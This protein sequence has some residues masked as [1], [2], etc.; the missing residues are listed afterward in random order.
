MKW[1]ALQH[2]GIRFPPAYESRQIKIRIRGEEVD[3]N[4]EQEEMVYQ[5]A[6]KKD[7][8]Y[9]QD[10]VFQ[11]NFTVDFAKT[12][13]REFRKISYKDIDFSDAYRIVDEEKAER[14]KRKEEEKEAR[15]KK[16]KE[17]KEA[18]IKKRKE[19]KEAMA[20]MT[21]EEREEFAKKIKEEREARAK[22]KKEEREAR[23][24][25]K[26]AERDKLKRKYGTAIM[27]GKKV[28]IANYMAEPPG[29]FIGRG[30]HPLRGRWKPR[31]DFKDVTLNLGKQAKVPKGD[32]GK[33]VSQSDATWLAKWTDHL[34]GNT[35]YVWL[36]D[37][38]GVKQDK[39]KE[40]YDKVAT[41]GK[42]I[43][44]I[45]KEM[46]RD[47]KSKDEKTRTI[48]TV[49]YLIYSTAMR[50]GDEKDSDEADTVGA[51]TLRK[52]H[53]TIT[54]NAVKFDFLGK[55][56]VE[57]QK[58]VK[59]EGDD[60]QFQENLKRIIGK[61]KPKDEIFDKIT[62]RRVNAYYSKI[63]PGMTAKV[64]RTYLA[65]KAVKDYLAKHDTIK[66]KSVDAKIH[67]AKLANLEAAKKCNHKR[68]I[69]KTFEKG[70]Q[71]RRDN[72]KIRM[73]KKPWEKT[74]KRR[75]Q[76]KDSE[77]KTDIQRKNKNKRIRRL[78]KQ[79]R[80]Q[81]ERHGMQIEKMKLQI[82]LTGKTK[83]YNL[84]T[85]LRNYID[86]RMFK[87]WADHVGVEWEKMYTSALQKKFLWVQNEK[88][89]WSEM[90]R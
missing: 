26:N 79:I 67:H 32:W 57:W 61:K 27:N 42:E 4:I 71:K 85:S 18:R 59:A 41:L 6:K 46:V 60:K 55:D 66:E 70:L 21:K 83:D 10:S 38:A 40:K 69:P 33:I 8:P 54:E 86:P 29:I 1:K 72:L 51:T 11:K 2:N 90:S 30:D 5:W 19:E 7:T 50:V 87:A 16:R 74:E 81:K 17:E 22:K 84:G 3:L 34:T 36:A 77:P 53:I 68:T 9:V 39:D 75:T 49:C 44:E 80:G 24:K 78:N 43:G 25:E 48:A 20:K 88:P 31:V 58:T 13:N 47:M 62:S 15:I 52:E 65:T 73:E 45:L 82:T 37:T 23:A 89:K 12:L 14:E 35:K 64:F 56:S 63:V 76:V 28:D